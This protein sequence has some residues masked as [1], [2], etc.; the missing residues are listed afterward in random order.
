MSP[1]EIGVQFHLPSHKDLSVPQILELG[2]MAVD[3]GV[4]QLWVTDNLQNRGFFVVLGALAAKLPV[5]LGAAIMVQYFRNPVDAAG[6][7]AAITELMDRSTELNIG[8]GRGNIR[9]SRFIKTDKPLA[10]M[11]ETAQVFHQLFAGQP[12]KGED[13]PA[14]AEYFNYAPG[15]VFSMNVLPNVP[16]KVYCGG[17]GP[18][19][20]AIGGKFMDG[21]L[22]GTTFYPLTKMGFLEPLLAI[23]DDAARR[24][25][26]TAPTRRV[27]EIKISLSR[28]PKASREF[29]RHGV[30]SR[31]LGLRWRGYSAED[32]G[33]LGITAEDIDRLEESKKSNG[34][35]SAELAPLVT[36]A[37]IDAYYVAGDLGHCRDRLAEVREMAEK[38]GFHQILLSGVSP[39][40][41]EGIKLLSEEIMPTW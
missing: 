39:N 22:C 24:A 14:V 25:G 37:M 35:T 19:S 16:I 17:D 28:D 29:A 9:T 3:G 40:L 12:I 38:H 5:K 34:G 26:K 2:E 32:I 1:V 18:K 20:L 33:R 6:S 30:G 41:K 7:L 8:I 13:Y 10:M 15:A 21:L 23:F 27:A 31:V 36:D 4:K 11:R